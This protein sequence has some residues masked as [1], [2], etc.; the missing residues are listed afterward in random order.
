[1]ILSFFKSPALYKYCILL[2]Q[3]FLQS[4][5]IDCFTYKFAEKLFVN[6]RKNTIP[7]WRNIRRCFGLTIQFYTLTRYLASILSPGLLAGSL[8]LCELPIFDQNSVTFA[9]SSDWFKLKGLML[10][11]SCDIFVGQVL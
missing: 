9:T 5:N 2:K 3:V 6:F 8:P 4:S 10:V 1:M 11:P 7:R